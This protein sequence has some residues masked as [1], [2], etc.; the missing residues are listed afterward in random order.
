MFPQK[1]RRDSLVKKKDSCSLNT[2]SNILTQQWKYL[3]IW[4]YWLIHG[5]AGVF[6]V[7]LFLSP[8]FKL[9]TLQY[10]QETT[11]SILYFIL[12]SLSLSPFPF[13]ILLLL[14]I[15]WDVFPLPQKY[16]PKEY[17]IISSLSLIKL[18]TGQRIWKQYL[19]H[20]S[21]IKISVRCLQLY[22]VY[23]LKVD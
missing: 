7:F 6:F 4:S 9:A 13:L 19:E 8:W 5:F 1:K 15:F 21:L 14:W 22:S 17:E 20:L 18:L 23:I 10:E 11:F 2:S 12:L 16:L 3:S